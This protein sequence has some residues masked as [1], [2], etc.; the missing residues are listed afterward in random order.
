MTLFDIL[1][2]LA[3][4]QQSY[5]YR[6]PQ[7]R[8]LPSVQISALYYLSRCN[9]YSNTPGAVAE[10]LGFTKGTISQ[11]L[12]KLESQGWI[13]REGDNHDKRIV[14]LFI[15]NKARDILYGVISQNAIDQA[16]TS[17]PHQGESLQA[18]LLLLLRQLQKQENQRIFGECYQCRF[19]QTE[20]G[21]PY[22]GLTKEPIPEENTR[23]ICREFQ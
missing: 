23:L 1:E 3:N 18:Q 19:H 17:L 14:R 7:L 2:R 4:L 13:I 5:F 20:Q 22:C 15:T 8:H 6:D 11:S 12:R 16:C 10:Y 9:H 21:K